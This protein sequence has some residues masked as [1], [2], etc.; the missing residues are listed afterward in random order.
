M[1]SQTTIDQ[2]GELGWCRYGEMEAALL[3]EA[4]QA[5]DLASVGD[6]EGLAGALRAGMQGCASACQ[7]ALGR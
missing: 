7:A 1:S 5:A 4:A 2:T 3:Q 6:M